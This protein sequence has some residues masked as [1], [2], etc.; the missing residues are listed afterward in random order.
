LFNKIG[1]KLGETSFHNQ[2]WHIVA[3]FFVWK[4][5]SYKN[6]SVDVADENLRGKKACYSA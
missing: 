5:P 4:V 1:E 6:C 3:I 2:E